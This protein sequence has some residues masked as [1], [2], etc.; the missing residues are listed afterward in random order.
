[1]VMTTRIASAEYLDAHDAPSL[2]R[3]NVVGSAG[4]MYW[5]GNAISTYLTSS[6]LSAKALKRGRVVQSKCLRS[7]C[8]DERAEQTVFT[9]PASCST[10]K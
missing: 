6:P 3:L 8:A 5:T 9:S 10:C 2:S 7:S 1:M 4:S